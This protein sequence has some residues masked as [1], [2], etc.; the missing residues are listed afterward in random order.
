[1]TFKEAALEILRKEKRPMKP[2]EIVEL[3]LQRGILHTRGETPWY[4]LSSHLYTDTKKNGSKSPFVQ[5]GKNLWGLREWN[6]AVLKDTIQKEENLKALEW[7]KAR[8][9]I[10]RSIV[11]DPI[12]VD[13]LTY[14][15]LNENG[16]IYLFAKLASKL[17]FIVEAIQ[18]AFPDAKARRR[19]GRGWEDVWI[20]FEYKASSFKAHRHDPSECDIIVCW[21][22]DW[23]DAPIEVLELKKH[24]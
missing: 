23:P 21:E 16:V 8:S 17:G 24:C 12:K 18:P 4:T 22:D 15:P 11:G 19:K 3:A 9:E 10:Q 13:G 2:K 20:E 14:A 6:L 7:H 1:M 5:L